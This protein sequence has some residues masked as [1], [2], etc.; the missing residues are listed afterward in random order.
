MRQMM[1]TEGGGAATLEALFNRTAEIRQK[2]PGYGLKDE[3]NSGFYNPIKHGVAQRTA[4]SASEAAKQDKTISQVLGGSNIIQGRTDQG[5]AGDPNAEGPGR[6]RVPG[7]DERYNYWTGRRRG[8]DFSRGD[9]ARFAE[10]QN[11]M[12]RTAS[13]PA[14]SG[15]GTEASEV[16]S[17]PA[18]FQADLTA[19]T[20]AGAQ[21]HNIHAY[22]LAHHINLSEATCGQ[23]M[24]SVV[25]EH[26]GQPPKDPAIA[27]NWNAFGGAQGAGY[28]DDP[29][30]INIAV[31]QGTGI[32]ATG[33]HVTGAI[34][35][36]DASG[37]I[38]GFRGVGVN[39]YNPPGAEHGIG[40][41]GH[42]VVSNRPITIGDRPG[43]YHIR[44]EI[45]DSQIA[46]ADID[47]QMT[48]HRVTGTGQLDVNVNAPKGT[49]VAARGGGLFKKTSVNR[50]AQME[51]AATSSGEE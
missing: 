21:P 5:M 7:S 1:K 6:I 30:A 46:R 10:G 50:R 41:Y 3:L 36:R 16:R 35:I 8:V 4:I 24:A 15:V 48:E 31:K 12:P 33:S 20:L 9:A 43:Q 17:V 28:S 27:S 14:G 29:N 34:P 19:M 32:G 51:A 37:K 40:D 39:Q 42:D 23:F 22:M 25:K 2:I 49:Q 45:V 44:H 47:R 26:G 13:T 11:A 38:T 18:K